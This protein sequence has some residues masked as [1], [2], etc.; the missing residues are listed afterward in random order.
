MI[1]AAIDDLFFSIKIKTAAKTLGAEVYFERAPDQVLESIRSKAPRLVI[2]D[3]D[4]V[5]LR[6]LEVLA[7][8]KG[9]P[10]LRDVATLGFVSHV[11]ADLIAAARAAGIDQ[12]LARSG[13]RGPAGIDSPVRRLEHFHDLV[14]CRQAAGCSAAIADAGA[15]SHV[16][17]QNREMELGDFGRRA[18]PELVAKS[19]TARREHT[20]RLGRVARAEVQ[21]HQLVVGRLAKRVEVDDLDGVLHRRHEIARLGAD[22]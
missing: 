17:P 9:D 5:K 10:A 20:Q 7:A 13:V 18:R 3:L 19:F 4:S 22:G 8:M 21:L 11:H 1:L 15:S 6:P 2:F 14:A 12:V 16:A